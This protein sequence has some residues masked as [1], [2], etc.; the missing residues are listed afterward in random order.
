MLHR[1]P[2]S[3]AEAQRDSSFLAGNTETF[4]KWKTE[5]RAGNRTVMM[6][7]H[8]LIFVTKGIKL[9]H[10]G[11]ETIQAHPGSV[12]LLRKGIYVMAEYIEPGLDFEALML[13]L[14]ASVLRAL[15]V[16]LGKSTVHGPQST[17]KMPG[18]TSQDQAEMRPCVVFRATDLIS[19]FRNGL[20]VFFDHRPPNLDALMALKQREILLLLMAAGYQLEVNAFIHSAVSSEAADIDYIVNSYLL[21]P[22]SIADLA[23]LAN[24]SLAKF[25]RDFQKQH[26]TSPRAWINAR[27]LE[28]A[29]ML[30]QNTKQTVSEV[31]NA[32][33]FESASH[34]IRLFRKAYGCTPGE[35]RVK[36]AIA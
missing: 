26:D 8:T 7:A 27:R 10:V 17:A 25:K 3:A 23:E 4:A 33:G 22:V 36:M 14:P 1:F 29:V 19:A 28:H 18:V 16:G 34:F 35:Q 32:C 21:Q 20:R 9:L 11:G 5:T 30:L 24:C 13:F 6:T 15:E 31:A 12:V 2:P